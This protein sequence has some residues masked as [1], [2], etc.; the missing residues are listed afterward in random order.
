MLNYKAFIWDYNGTLLDDLSIGVLSIN[1]MLEK[2][3]LPLL[4]I[5]HYR[6]V[7]TFPVKSYYEAVGFDFETEDWDKAA[8]EFI[9]HYTELLPQ[10][11]IFPEA[12][13]LLSLFNKEGKKQFI[14]SAMEQNML[15][16]STQSEEISQYFDEISGIDNIYASSKIDNGLQLM[17]KHELQA[18]EV[19]LF[20]DTTH[21]FEVAKKLGCDCIL[22]ASGHQSYQKLKE[23]GCP[24]VVNHIKEI[25]K[26]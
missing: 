1:K 17:K 21:D 20:G 12:I 8:N 7:F 11:G 5:E 6:E 23:T 26:N 18:N 10:S 24:K 15:H 19:C 2:R 3:G 4:T 13:D 22:I 14:L 25:I 9:D 16:N